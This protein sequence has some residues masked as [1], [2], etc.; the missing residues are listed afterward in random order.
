MLCNME[1]QK[2]RV[3]LT[4]DRLFLINLQ[5][6]TGHSCLTIIQFS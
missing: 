6:G 1:V 2:G 4:G 5:A 3:S